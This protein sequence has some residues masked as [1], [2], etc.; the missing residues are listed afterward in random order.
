MLLPQLDSHSIENAPTKASDRPA[1]LLVLQHAIG[2]NRKGM[3]N[4]RYAK[5]SCELASKTTIAILRSGH[6]VFGDELFP[7]LLIVIQADAQSRCR[8]AG[9]QQNKPNRPHESP[10]RG[11]EVL[12]FRRKCAADTGIRPSRKRK[13]ILKESAVPENGWRSVDARWSHP[14]RWPSPLRPQPESAPTRWPGGMA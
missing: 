6:F 2:I 11:F 7:F 9:N 10:L 1:H 5:H 14:D 4:C 8:R 3:S 13:R 12:L